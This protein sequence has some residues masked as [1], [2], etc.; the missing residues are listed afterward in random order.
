MDPSS[1]QLRKGF[2]TRLGE[3]RRRWNLTQGQLAELVGAERNTVRRWESG[4]HFPR[5]EVLVLL[6][7][8]LHVSLDYLVS[9]TAPVRDTR[10]ITRVQA[11]DTLGPG[12]VEE[13]LQLVDSYLD[14]RRARTTPGGHRHGT[15]S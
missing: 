13:V 3:A 12:A 5:A 14:R 10:L 9:G 4:D 11:V 2:G 7:Q 6:S 1:T 8:V 15:A